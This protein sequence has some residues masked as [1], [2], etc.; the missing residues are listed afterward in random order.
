M[1]G[2]LSQPDVSVQ[3]IIKQLRAQLQHHRAA[4]QF[5]GVELKK[6]GLAAKHLEAALQ[7]LG[8]PAAVA[9]DNRCEALRNYLTDHPHEVV[10]TRLL[11]ADPSKYGIIT[12]S[13][14]FQL[15]W[16]YGKNNPTARKF[17]NVANGVIMLR[18]GIAEN[19]PSS[20]RS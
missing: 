1:P 18:S 11:R 20:D 12:S 4:Q 15:N 7:E 19:P 8:E 14:R 2:Q 10:T 13:T 5:H 17:F 16:L 3:E 9:S 6:H